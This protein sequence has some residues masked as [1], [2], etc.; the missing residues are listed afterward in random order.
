MTRK[1]VIKSVASA[2]TW[3]ECQKAEQM[4][5]Q[6]MEEHPDD[7]M[8]RDAGEV[9]EMAKEGLEMPAPLAAGA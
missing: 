9:L 5:R 2:M 4:L 8:M 7:M 1:E 3:E 6:W